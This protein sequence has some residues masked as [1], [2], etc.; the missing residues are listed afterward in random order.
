MGNDYPVIW[1][2]QVAR[3]LSLVTVVTAATN[4]EVFTVLFDIFSANSRV[5][6]PACLKITYNILFFISPFVAFIGFLFAKPWGFLG[7]FVFPLVALLFGISA[8]PFVDL[9]FLKND[10]NNF[11]I[12][13][14][15]NMLFLFV[16][17]VLL[18]KY[19]YMKA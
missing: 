17:W 10:E 3:V 12:K 8:I 2:M 13:L 9:L 7:L 19:K 15:I 16:T 6:C 14:V 11:N 18:N 1:P 4:T 5:S